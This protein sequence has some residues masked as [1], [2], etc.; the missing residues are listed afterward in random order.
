MPASVLAL[1][2]ARRFS[3]VEQPYGV[4]IAGAF[5]VVILGLSGLSRYRRA[6][7]LRVNR[8][9][10]VDDGLAALWQ[11]MANRRVNLVPL[12]TSDAAQR[13]WKASEIRE[14]Y[15]LEEP[16]AFIHVYLADNRSEFLAN[17]RARR[18]PSRTP[19]LT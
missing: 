18:W 7:E 11:E 16:L 14:H 12:W 2:A 15:R 10:L 17:L 8:L 19:S 6:T 13:A 4:Y 1:R 3:V 9:T 5:I